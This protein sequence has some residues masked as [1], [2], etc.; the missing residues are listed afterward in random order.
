VPACC[1]SVIPLAMSETAKP[2]TT[3]KK[4]RIVQLQVKTSNLPQWR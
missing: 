1:A 4:A 3:V 2:N